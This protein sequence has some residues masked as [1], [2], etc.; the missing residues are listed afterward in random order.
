MV[1]DKLNYELIIYERPELGPDL[2]ESISR[3]FKGLAL[4]E[5][6]NAPSTGINVGTWMNY[7]VSEGVRGFVRVKINRNTIVKS[8]P[9]K[10]PVGAIIGF[11][12]D[13]DG[14]RGGF[15]FPE[16]M[17]FGLTNPD[18]LVRLIAENGERITKA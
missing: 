14:T 18:G 6:T 3:C 15:V 9:E 2:T 11:R 17:I 12:C 10:G 1:D 8:D 16:V 7:N 13:Y 4:E 5:L